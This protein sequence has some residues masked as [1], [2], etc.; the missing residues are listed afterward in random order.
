MTLTFN[1]RSKTEWTICLY[2]TKHETCTCLCKW[3]LHLK[4]DIIFLCC[5]ENNL[6]RVFLFLLM[7]LSLPQIALTM[8]AYTIAI[9]VWSPPAASVQLWSLVYTLHYSGVVLI[10]WIFLMPWNSMNVLP[11]HPQE[12]EKNTCF[13]R[14]ILSDW[15][16][17]FLN[18]LDRKSERS[19]A[20]VID[21]SRL[22][23]AK[24]YAV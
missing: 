18:V 21:V 3:N 17:G 13:F 20:E 8:F 6:N 12:H 7:V 11:C 1:V 9:F 23:T 16:V 24:V 19:L 22:S 4:H 2:L 5:A 14:V 15:D 10:Q